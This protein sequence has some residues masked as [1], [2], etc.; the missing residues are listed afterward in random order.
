MAMEEDTMTAT[1]AH[2]DVPYRVL[3]RTGERV[4][5]IG[6][7]GWHLGLEHVEEPLSIRIVRTAIDHGINFMDN[8]WDYNEGKSELRMGKAL[9]GSYREKVF[10]M[11]KI[12]GRSKKEAARQ[13]DES[14]RRLQTDRIDLVQH[15]EILRYEDPHRIFDEEGANAALVKARQAGKLRY[16]GFTGHKDPH[17]HLHMLEVAKENGF[18]FDTAQMPLNV[19][20]AHYRSFEKLVLPELVQ[21]QIG[22]LGM[23]PL[24]NGI[25]LKSKTVTATEGLHYALNLP[26]SVVITGC[27]SMKILEQA[28][29]AARTFQ[30]MGEAEVR[31]LLAKTAKA[32]SKGEFELFKTTS[33]FDSTASNPEWLGDEPERVRRVMRG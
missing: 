32:A 20:D 12:D 1:T 26:T 11:T 21:Q 18:A 5:A 2:A 25:I 6:L 30:P 28:L 29:E 27:D 7:G 31:A 13:L 9:K 4:S 19:M 3:G 15:H 10:L 17:I 23:K 24:A 22:V 16:I 14:L 8:S 33:I